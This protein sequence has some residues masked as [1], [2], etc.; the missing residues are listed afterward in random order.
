MAHIYFFTAIFKGTLANSFYIKEFLANFINYVFND[1]LQLFSVLL[2]IWWKRRRC[3][4][5]E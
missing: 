2:F 3:S 4:M 1:W 5:N